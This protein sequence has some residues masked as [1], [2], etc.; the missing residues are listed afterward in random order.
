MN[1]L[2]RTIPLIIAFI[3][4]VMMAFQYYVPHEASQSLL[5]V[6]T[7]WGI[8]IA[9]FA[10]F[11]GAYSLFHLHWAKIKR[12]VPG[13]GYSMFVFL[14]LEL[15]LSLVCIMEANSSGMTNR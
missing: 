1:F 9:G 15:L 11:I 4:G 14:A 10:V 6:V 2:K 7:R 3:M 8:T 12:K 13:W 5:K